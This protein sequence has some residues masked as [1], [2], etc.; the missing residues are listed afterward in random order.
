MSLVLYLLALVALALH[1]SS[2][3]WPPGMR[4][5]LIILALAG[6]W[7]YGWGLVHLVRALLYRRLVFPEWRRAA[8]RQG[9]AALASQV[10][11]VIASYRIRGE[12]MLRAFEAALAEAVRYERPVTIVAAIV[13]LGDQR[14]IKQL[15]LRM[16][17]PAEVRLI[18]V[19]RPAAGKRHGLAC[20]LRAVARDR[21]APD[22]AVVVVD[23]DTLLTPGTL[24]RSLPFLRLMPDVD[25]ITTDQDC[26]V[27]AGP[28]LRAWHELRFAQRHQLMSSLGLGRRL[29]A[30]SGRMAVYRG[31]VA[32]DPAFIAAIEHDRLEHWRLGPIRL[33]TGADRSAW[34]WLLQR[35]RAMLY[36]PDVKVVTIEHPPGRWLLPAA[37]RLMRRRCGD[38][39]RAN[40]R[41]LA[42]GPRRIGAFAWWCLIDQRVSMWTI[43]IGPT[44]ALIFV[45]GKSP[46]FVYTYLLWVGMTRL[47]QVLLL[48]TARPRIS[49][50]YPP[51][52]YFGQVYGA[53]VKTWVLFRLD[54][55]RWTRQDI[56]LPGRAGLQRLASTYLHLLALG[57]LVIGAAFAT[58]LLSLPSLT[59]AGGP[60]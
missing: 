4:E 32:T 46:L 45:L 51:L 20:A 27:H 35:G 39:L 50:L 13:E 34:F 8:D 12:T 59:G 11:V 47:V 14:A 6:A 44:V 10:Y 60:Y 48:L 41:A 5:F 55:Q 52:L 42:L 36:L 43:L 9:P 31:R 29:L 1:A 7:R 28:A 57:A 25:G 37:T 26:L 19:R 15:F 33:L 49:G 2:A 16:S 53:L 24:A 40:G 18:F 56:A 58:R 38:M 17:P 54:R 21:P 22:A 23:G 3:G 30:M